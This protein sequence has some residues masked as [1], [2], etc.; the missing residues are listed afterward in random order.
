MTY[1]ADTTGSTGLPD[2]GTNAAVLASNWAY[3]DS[4]QNP[5]NKVGYYF[6]YP[7]GYTSPQYACKPGVGEFTFYN[8]NYAPPM[9]P[10][11][12]FAH[13]VALLG[14][15]VNNQYEYAVISG[16]KTGKNCNPL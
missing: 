10:N 16:D 11:Y 4:N 7:V 2:T 5:G 6:D 8:T 3:L 15:V 1:T 9:T 12:Y 14:P 13:F